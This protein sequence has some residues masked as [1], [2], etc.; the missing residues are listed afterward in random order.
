M[1]KAETIK[2]NFGTV[3]F[4]RRK[5]PRFSINL[6]VEYWKIDRSTSAFSRTGDISE[7]GLLL[8]IFE[9]IEVG[10]ELNLKLFFNS[11]L[12]LESIEARVQVAWKDYWFEKESGHRVGLKFV[13]IS[14]EDMKKLKLFL[15]NLMHLKTHPTLNPSP[16]LLVKT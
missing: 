15:N 4:E 12:G 3:N 13:E 2:P 14:G 10:Q 9:Q 8:Y 1:A 7:G 11:D 6:P 16:G 5:H